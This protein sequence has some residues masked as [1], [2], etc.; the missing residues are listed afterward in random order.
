MSQKSLLWP[1]AH[2]MPPWY[3]QHSHIPSPDL[4]LVKDINHHPKRGNDSSHDSHDSLMTHL[5]THSWLTHDSTY[6]SLMTHLWLTLWLIHDSHYDSLMTHIMTPYES[7][8][9]YDFVYDSSVS[10]LCPMTSFTTHLWVNYALLLPLRLLSESIMLYDSL[11]DSSLSQLCFMTP[12]TTHPW[13]NY[14]LI[15]S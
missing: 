2:I 11:H 13:V 9:L 15:I 10:Q 7:I 6:D 1:T 3:L 14:D 8:M 12:F 4:S 5:R